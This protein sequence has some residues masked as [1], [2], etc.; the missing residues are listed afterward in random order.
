MGVLSGKVAWVTGA[1]TGIGLA[2][3]PYEFLSLFHHGDLI[4]HPA[5]A[6]NGPQLISDQSIADGRIRWR[7]R[8][9]ASG[10]RLRISACRAVAA[11]CSAAG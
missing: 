2:R 3:Q 10:Y 6:Q 8:F 11:G 4:S 5:V 7:F 9:P 1:G